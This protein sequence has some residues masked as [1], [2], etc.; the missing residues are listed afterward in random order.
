MAQPGN[1]TYVASDGDLADLVASMRGADIL[2]V[3]TEFIRERTYWA[4]LCLIQVN[5]GTHA[6]IIDPFEVDDLGPLFELFADESIV[7]V[8]HAGSQDPE[9]FHKMT[10]SVPAPVF[11]TQVAAALASFPLQAGYGQLVRELLGV[12]LDKTHSFT[13]WA[14][15]PLSDRQLRY[16]LDDVEYLPEVYRLVLERLERD[17]RSDWL[18]AD[19][20]EMEDPATYEV[21]PEETY[22]R[23]KR[24][25]RLRRREMGVLKHVSAWREREA[26][27]RDV[28]R[29][30]IAGDET[31]VQIA[32][33]K[34][35]KRSELDGVRGLHDSVVRRSGEDIVAAVAAGLAMLES[36]LP[37]APRRGRG[38][39]DVDVMTDLMSAVVRTRA[40][41]YGI[42]VPVLASRKEMESL[43][44]GEREDSRLLHGWRRS[45][46]G[47]ELVDLIE[48]RLTLAL[49]GEDVVI[50]RG[51]D[52]S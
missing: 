45:H 35:R 2:A 20:A 26:M 17:G 44:R 24:R 41:E 15:R 38:R 23:V 43:A 12:D 19:F 50:S 40:R 34:P 52:E 7:K 8:L 25:K 3:D 6:A 49:D 31:L 28:P 10:G 18:E 36:E 9:I 21:V 30:R 14:K 42:A 47:E 13:D 1:L 27:R 48:G 51:E 32:A 16:A 22:R 5:D 46:I 11:D 4:R 39:M 29:N 33:R 37:E